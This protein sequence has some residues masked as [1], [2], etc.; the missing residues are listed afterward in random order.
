MP[1][2]YDEYQANPAIRILREATEDTVAEAMI[3]INAKPDLS[4]PACKLEFFQRMVDIL[5]G[6]HDD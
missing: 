6:E 1:L 3:D 4:T 2:T 5:L